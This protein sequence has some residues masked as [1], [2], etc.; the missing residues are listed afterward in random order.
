MEYIEK[1]LKGKDNK[2][3]LMD[4]SM[5]EKMAKF[6]RFL[7]K[8]MLK[9]NINKIRE[10]MGGDSRDITTQPIITKDKNIPGYESHVRIQIYAPEISQIRPL[11]VFF[12]GG[13]WI[14]GSLPAVENYCKGVCDR[15]NCVVI[16][17]D[18]HLAPENPFP[19]GLEDSYAAIK[20]AVANKEDLKIDPNQISV[21]GDSAGGNFA[22]VLSLMAKDRKEFSIA[23]QILIYPVTNLVDIMVSDDVSDFPFPPG[24]IKVMEVM[25][26]LY[27]KGKVDKR[28]SY[29][30]PAFAK[31]LSN[32]PPALIAVGD[33]DFLYKSSLK[34]AEKLDEAGNKV[35]FI[36]YKN[37]N[38]AF[39]DDTGNSDQ[40]DD[41]VKE[42]AEFIQN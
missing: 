18:Y 39:I 35:K 1:E 31:D 38:H 19:E 23:K 33:Q 10:S 7:L 9:K 17:V 30:S 20:W 12:H 4:F 34:Y 2:S 26:S 16:S 15:A 40:A 8:V 28:N 11:L 6:P 41:L 25:N 27:F 13:G 36:L 22:A 29:L 14:G 3:E 5:I 37:A 42:A 21:G 32:L 24:M